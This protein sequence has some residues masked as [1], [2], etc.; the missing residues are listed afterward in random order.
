M[1]VTDQIQ[2][3]NIVY[4]CSSNTNPSGLSASRS[5]NFANGASIQKPIVEPI[6]TLPFK[7]N[8]KDTVG[9]FG[10]E[11]CFVKIN[12][13]L[14]GSGSGCYEP[15]G[16]ECARETDAVEKDPNYSD[17]GI[18]DQQGAYKSDPLKDLTIENEYEPAQWSDALVL[19]AGDY[20]EVC[21]KNLK[22]GNQ[23]IDD[24]LDIRL[25]TSQ[26]E[27]HPY[28]VMYIHPKDTFYIGFHARNTRRLPYNVEL[29]FGDNFIDR[30]KLTADERRYIMRRN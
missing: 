15:P 27:E 12:F 2:Q 8:Y 14:L 21:L 1:D 10:A 9:L 22:T 13:H 28:D 7:I 3:I 16:W 23:Y 17:I 30:Y 5:L 6:A 18:P 19:D 29:T 25:Y 11:N 24:W 26:R 4:G 20:I